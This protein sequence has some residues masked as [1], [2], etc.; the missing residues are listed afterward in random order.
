MRSLFTFYRKLIS[1]NKHRFFPGIAITA[2][3]VLGASM[4]SAATV[5]LD[6]NNVTGILNLGITNQADEVIFYDVGFVF[7]SA[8]DVYDGPGSGPT[9]PF[10][11]EEDA[12][13]AQ[14]AV[15][16]FLNDEVSPVPTGAGTTGDNQFF[17]GTEYDDSSSAPLMVSL[18]LEY[19]S[20]PQGQWL[21]CITQPCVLDNL[22]LGIGIMLAQDSYTYATFN[23]PVPV[24]AAAWLFGSALIGLAGIGRKRRA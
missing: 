19:F 24:P 7:G 14:K 12:F 18:G 1:S 17:I 10:L 2:C 3:L 20:S 4:G 5:V 8:N 23:A 22:G 11:N 15:R 16:D 13:L 6:G 9:L 21:E